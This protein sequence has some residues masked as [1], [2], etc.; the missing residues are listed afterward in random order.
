MIKIN[1]ITYSNNMKILIKADYIFNGSI[2][3]PEGVERINE[4]AFAWTNIT[5]VKFPSSLR[6]IGKR[7]FAECRYL[8]FVDFGKSNYDIL[9]EPL[10]F[11]NCIALKH[12]AIPGNIETI[13]YSCFKGC[14]IESVTFEE[15]VRIIEEAAFWPAS[16]LKEIKLPESLN[17]IDIMN[18]MNIKI[19]HSSSYCD[20]IASICMYSNRLTVYTNKRGTIYIPGPISL[21]YIETNHIQKMLEDYMKGKIENIYYIDMINNVL[22]PSLKFIHAAEIYDKT[23]DNEVLCFMKEHRSEMKKYLLEYENVELLTK[24]TNLDIFSEKQLVD[25]LHNE[26]CNSSIPLKAI[27]LDKLKK[28][29]FESSKFNI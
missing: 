26:I 19:V 22:S 12:V 4:G 8:E 13:G 21:R 14:P 11:Y 25:I 29:S 6:Y 15:G 5:S 7:A 9:S 3:I 28:Q 20:G 23:H 10:I 17:V 18:F 2:V 1:G 16:N 24:I 27:V